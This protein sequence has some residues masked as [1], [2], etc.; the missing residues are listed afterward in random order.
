MRNYNQLSKKKKKELKEKINK[1]LEKFYQDNNNNQYNNSIPEDILNRILQIACLYEII[2][3]DCLNNEL[4][5]KTV[6]DSI[7]GVNSIDAITEQILQTLNKH[8]SIYSIV[9]EEM[10]NSP[11]QSYEN[12]YEMEL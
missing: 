10:L 2:E 11:E 8:P 1:E 7:Y 3:K 5:S 12:Y 4:Y 9:I 6:K